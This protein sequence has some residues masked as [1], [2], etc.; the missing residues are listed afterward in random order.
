[1]PDSDKVL[2]TQEWLDWYRDTW[3]QNGV[4]DEKL[5]RLTEE[6]EVERLAQEEK[7]KTS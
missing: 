5:R 7:R 2:V 3:Y 4:T 1:M 6:L